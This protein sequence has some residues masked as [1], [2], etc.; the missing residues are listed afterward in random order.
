MSIESKTTK[1]PFCLE[2]IKEISRYRNYV[3][4]NCI[5]KALDANG[6]PV[7]YRNKNIYGGF[8][9]M[10]NIYGTIIKKEDR[11]CFINGEKCLASEARF[12]GIVVQKYE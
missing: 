4:N 2:T 3:C 11:I 6:N 7:S 5:N 8:V 10:H 12:G 9:S 1:C